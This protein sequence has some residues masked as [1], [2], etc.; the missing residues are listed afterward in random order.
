MTNDGDAT[1]HE[2]REDATLHASA[3]VAPAPAPAPAFAD[4]KARR[5]H[6]CLAPLSLLCGARLWHLCLPA[7]SGFYF[8]SSG[9]QFW[10][11]EYMTFYRGFD[12][13]AVNV[14]IPSLLI[15]C[16]LLGLVGGAA[17]MDRLGGYDGPRGNVRA[18]VYLLTASTIGTAFGA[19]FIFLPLGTPFGASMIPLG[20]GIASLSALLPV[21]A[22][23]S[24][25][26]LPDR[27]R[28]FGNAC[29]LLIINVAGFGL[30]SYIPGLVMERI[31]RLNEWDVDFKQD[32]DDTSSGEVR[33]LEDSGFRNSRTTG[34]PDHRGQLLN[35][36][37]WIVCGTSCFL[38]LLGSTLMLV[39]SRRKLLASSSPRP[40]AALSKV[41]PTP[42]AEKWR[43][44]R[45]DKTDPTS[46]RSLAGVEVNSSLEGA[47][48]AQPK[49]ASSGGELGTQVDQHDGDSAEETPPLNRPQA[50]PKWM[51]ARR[52]ARPAN[53]RRE[54]GRGETREPLRKAE[55]AREEH[56][57]PTSKSRGGDRRLP[58]LGHER[59][60]QMQNFNHTQ[61][62]AEI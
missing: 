15:V 25:S 7:F 12:R 29:T 13:T 1:S 35:Y 26:A 20:L 59:K 22:G 3:S 17:V 49:P 14:I 4:K 41:V 19:A 38:T 47:T 46:E 42:A 53:P 39:F 33:Q 36:G 50:G 9:F 37:M 52:E 58:S 10:A 56:G 34:V 60:G 32:V 6:P 24:I 30:G 43:Q 27:A 16:S 51:D 54:K 11:T 45:W 44:G 57:S 18:S 48:V 55:Q 2:H 23:L 5:R 8:F 62:T 61:I 28:I 31:S 21:I 40:H